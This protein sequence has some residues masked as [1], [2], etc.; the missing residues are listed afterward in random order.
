[1]EVGGCAVF[2]VILIRSFSAIAI[3]AD[4]NR[5]HSRHV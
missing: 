3:A 4:G 1:M 5:L 2:R